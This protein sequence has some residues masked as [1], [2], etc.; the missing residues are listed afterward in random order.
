MS[1][2]LA[3]IERLRELAATR[4]A[5]GVAAC[6]GCP[7]FAQNICSGKSSET[8]PCPPPVAQPKVV[9]TDDGDSYRPPTSYQQQLRSPRQSFVAARPR[10]VVQTPPRST[11]PRRKPSVPRRSRRESSLGE[12][13]ADV[14]LA[15]FGV[16][17]ITATKMKQNV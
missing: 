12:R 8:A 2:Q 5:L 15:S 1:E 10:P 6:A 4:R 14:V 13:L 3:T 9:E 17:A 16:T 7:L 11:Q